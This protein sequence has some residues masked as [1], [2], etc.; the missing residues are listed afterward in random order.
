MA[1]QKGLGVLAG[2][3]DLCIV[4]PDGRTIWL[5]MKRTKGGVQS[6]AQKAW[7]E[8]VNARPNDYYILGIGFE[9]A[10]NK[11]LE[12]LTGGQNERTI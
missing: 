4:H 3:S 10:K 2:V 7:E 5:E 1:S 6:D 11:V 12:I 8:Y 9:D